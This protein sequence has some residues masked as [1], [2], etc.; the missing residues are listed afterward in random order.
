MKLLQP[1]TQVCISYSN[2]I[3][4]NQYPIIPLFP[5]FEWISQSL[6][7]DKPNGRPTLPPQVFKTYLK[8]KSYDISIDFLRASSLLSIFNFLRNLC[9]SPL[10]QKVFKFM[11][12]RL[13]ENI[14]FNIIL[15]LQALNKKKLHKNYIKMQMA[16]QTSKKSIK[17]DNI[18]ISGI[19]FVSWIAV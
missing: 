13:L 12:S 18:Q 2:L 9:I 6:G 10:L 7:Q 15:K 1:P 11:V 14:F 19:R 8:D 16:Q 4:Q 3:F 17:F 5:L